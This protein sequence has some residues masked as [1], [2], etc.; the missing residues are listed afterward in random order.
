MIQGAAA[1]VV[2]S[3]VSRNG[4]DGIQVS[5]S[6]S[7]RV[8]I[9][10]DGS[11]YAGNTIDGNGGHG[12]SVT[13]AS[14]AAVGGNTITGNGTDA[15]FGRPF[16]IVVSAS[17][18]SVVG[19]NNIAGNV[20]SGVSANASRVVVG[21]GSFGLPI[22]NTISGNGFR[23]D[24]TN[25]RGG[26]FAF[27]AGAIDI[28]EAT[29]W[30]NAGAGVS[31]FEGGVVDVRQNTTIF[32][33]VFSAPGLYGGHGVSAGLRSVARVRETVS[34]AGNA[35]AG[36][37]VENGS[38]VDFRGVSTITENSGYGLNCTGTEASFSGVTTGITGNQSGDIAPTCT[39][40]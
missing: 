18:V 33:N 14:G 28:R 39:G 30:G 15:S 40:F 10:N 34:I 32:G 24:T 27:Q 16:G 11:A 17:G 35:G 2:R 21:D 36:V 25:S 29:I 31:A 9:L 26:A 12:I 1:T 4:R 6:G 20:G 13:N 22:Q 19:G 37:Y 3:N 8:G 5:I 23:D 38:A 7:A